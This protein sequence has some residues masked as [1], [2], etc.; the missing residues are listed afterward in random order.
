MHEEAGTTGL[1]MLKNMGFDKF[2]GDGRALSMLP[3][4]LQDSADPTIARRPPV[5]RR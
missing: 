3:P 4:G 5:S 2:D 1:A